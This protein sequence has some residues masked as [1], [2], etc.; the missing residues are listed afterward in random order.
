M[1]STDCGY[2][3]FTLRSNYIAKGRST[4]EYVAVPRLPGFSLSTMVKLVMC[5]RYAGRAITGQVSTTPAETILAEA[6]LPTVATM[7]T[8][9]STI[10]MVKSD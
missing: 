7:A 10:A 9:L 1:A 4:V 3:K 5:Q 6:D 8:N 2:V